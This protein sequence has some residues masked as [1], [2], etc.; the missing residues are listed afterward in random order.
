[1]DCKEGFQEI[2][3]EDVDVAILHSDVDTQQDNCVCW[4]LTHH[5]AGGHDIDNVREGHDVGCTPQ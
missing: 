5:V 2:S 1:M 3:G 4:Q